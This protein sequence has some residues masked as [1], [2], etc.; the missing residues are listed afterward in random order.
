MNKHTAQLPDGNVATRNSKTRTYT[1]AIALG[2]SKAS[3][4]IER[5][6]SRRDYRANE[7][8]EYIKIVEALPTAAIA[9]NDRGT[10]LASGVNFPVFSSSG[11]SNA[12]EAR[13]Y[14]LDQYRNFAALSGDAVSRMNKEIAELS[15]G[16][17][18]VGNWAVVTWCGRPDL[19]A[20]QAASYAGNDSGSE[21]RVI[22]VEVVA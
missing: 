21:V 1:H 8:L 15:E 14:L 16:P 18:L 10:W 7:A 5:L 19:A 2:P 3:K 17:E 6:E 20:K 22:E 12:D 11:V 4:L 9:Q 13:E